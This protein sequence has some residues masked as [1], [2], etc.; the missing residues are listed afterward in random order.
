MASSDALVLEQYALRAEISFFDRFRIGLWRF[1]TKKPLGA[2]GGAIVIVLLL[3]AVFPAVFATHDPNP[4]PPPILDRLQGPSASHWMGTDQQGR[5]VYSRIVF[6]A[7]T[8]ITIGFL[9]I[10]VSAILA[11]FIGTISG[12]FGGW[13]DIIFQRVVDIGIA[14]PGLV[15]IILAVTSLKERMKDILEPLGFT[16]E[17]SVVVVLSLSLGLLVSLGSSRVIRGAAISAKQNV[18]VEAARVVGATD[19]RIMVKHIFPNVFA[20]VLVS[21]SI[22]IGGAILTESAL[23]FL[24]YG[25][26]PPTPSWG[27]MLTEAREYLTRYPHLAIFP[28]LAIFFA[29]YSFNMLGDALRD[30][31]DPRLRGSR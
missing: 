26:Q 20:V 18:Y 27:R 5:D 31:L 16:P 13:V 28:G 15:F 6:G 4:S 30:V 14:L 1:I 8:S 25:V 17:T 2:F 22:Q 19:A 12:Y 23:S 21:A 29:V 9:V 11:S 7:R 24:G 10:F 3:M